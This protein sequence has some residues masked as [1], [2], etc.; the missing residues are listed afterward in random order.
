MNNKSEV[1]MVKKAQAGDLSQRLSQ[2]LKKEDLTNDEI[3]D[4]VKQ[5]FID[6]D[7]IR[8]YISIVLKAKR[9]GKNVWDSPTFQDRFIS[10]LIIQYKKSI[11]RTNDSL[12]ILSSM[13]G[14]YKPRK[15]S[16]KG[17]IPTIEEVFGDD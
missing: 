7:L 11:W 15:Q 3:L 12:I 2:M 8:T 13:L 14:E 1:P 5:I 17:E 4:L 16:R 10:D 9:K 6:E